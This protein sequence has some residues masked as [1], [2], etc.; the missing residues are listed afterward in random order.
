M[1]TW[2]LEEG[3]VPEPD[4]LFAVARDEVSWTSQMSSRQTA[5]MGIPYNYAGATYPEAPW[6]PALWALAL[7]VGEAVGL[8]PTN[9]LLNRYPTGDHSIGWHRDD[10]TI[11]APGTGVAILSLGAPR[12]LLLREGAAPPFTTERVLLPPG[13]LFFMSAALQA[14]HKHAIR[15]EPGAGERI[16]VTIRQLTHAPPPVDR[17]RWG[18]PP[19]I[20]L[21]RPSEE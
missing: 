19:T 21:P 17:P 16:S 6:H 7:R 14:T 5:S 2:W 4:A 20:E 1:V 11:L 12:T 9:A 18:T 10:T 3:F 15:R 8:H 13:S